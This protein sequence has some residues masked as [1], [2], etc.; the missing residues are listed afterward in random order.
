MV[1]TKHDQENSIKMSEEYI[2]LQ[3][4]Q[5]NSDISY[6]SFGL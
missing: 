1:Q 3:I 5:L 4:T 6:K 2:L